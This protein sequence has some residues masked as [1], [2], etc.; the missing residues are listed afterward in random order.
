MSFAMFLYPED[1]IQ[2]TAGT[3]HGGQGGT[4]NNVFMDLNSVYT[5]IYV[6]NKKLSPSIKKN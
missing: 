4:D 1:G 3:S 2:W 6:D 5:Y